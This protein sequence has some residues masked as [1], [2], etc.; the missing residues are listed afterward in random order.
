V[1]TKASLFGKDS[2]VGRGMAITMEPTGQHLSAA[3]L[4][5]DL[6]KPIVACC[7]IILTPEPGLITIDD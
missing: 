3:S 6:G 7:S 1:S 4:G 2:V 5:G